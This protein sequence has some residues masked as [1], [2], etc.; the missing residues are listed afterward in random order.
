MRD[1]NIP[2]T[3]PLV[4]EKTLAIQELGEGSFKSTDSNTVPDFFAYFHYKKSFK[5]SL[6]K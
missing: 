1:V 6:P 4:K 2:R 5:Y 3:P